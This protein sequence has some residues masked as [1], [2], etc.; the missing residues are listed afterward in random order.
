MNIKGVW[1][2]FDA[3]YLRALMKKDRKM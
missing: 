3:P 1:G 2:E